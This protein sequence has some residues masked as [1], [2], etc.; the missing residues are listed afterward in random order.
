LKLDNTTENRQG[1]SKVT[2]GKV[3][4]FFLKGNRVYF[5]N[6]IYQ[7]CYAASTSTLY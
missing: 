3:K 2:V 5:E 7:G 6:L 1:L 4:N